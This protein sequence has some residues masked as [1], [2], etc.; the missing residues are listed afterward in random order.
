[1]RDVYIH[2]ETRINDTQREEMLLYTYY[3]WAKERL[4]G[5]CELGDG[6]RER[7]RS[8]DN[9]KGNIWLPTRSAGAAV[10]C[11]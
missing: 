3:K 9:E 2:T 6:K 10:I 1:M 4:K 8:V 5:V 11:V 7:E